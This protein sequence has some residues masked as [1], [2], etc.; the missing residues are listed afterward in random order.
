[1]RCEY[2]WIVEIYSTL[3]RACY[4][5]PRNVFDCYR[6]NCIAA[7][8][9]PRSI[10]VINRMMPG[11]SI[12]VCEGDEI[13]VNV[14]NKLRSQRVT[15]IHWHGLYQKRSPHMDGASMITQCPILPMESFQYRFGYFHFIFNSYYG[16]LSGNILKT[17]PKMN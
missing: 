17:Y 2:T 16:R 11:P 6:E 13:V 1:M 5:C 7:N 8:G 10:E 14:K 12:Q 4:D 3:S 9:L 15:T